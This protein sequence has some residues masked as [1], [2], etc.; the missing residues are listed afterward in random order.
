[1]SALNQYIE[2]YLSNRDLVCDNCGSALN[3]QRPHALHSL[4]HCSLPKIGSENY[5]HTD[6]EEILAPD[7][8]LNLARLNSDINPASAFRCG[9]PNITPALFYVLNDTPV[10]PAEKAELPEGVEIGSLRE[11]SMRGEKW[12]EDHY[13]KLADIGNPVTALDTLLV[14]DGLAIHVKKGVKLEKPLQL[15]NIL[16]ANAPLMA[17]RRLL[18][19]IEDDAKAALLVCDHT[20]NSAQDFLS[21]QTIE[22]FTGKNAEFDL[23]D[24]EESSERTKRLSTLYLSQQQGSN[25]L[26]D[27]ITLYNGRTRNEYHTRFTGRDASLKLLGMGIEDKQRVLE[28]Y[29]RISHDVPGCNTD[30]LFKYVVDDNARGSFTGLV[31]VAPGAEKTTAYQSNRNI[32]GS[33]QALMFSKPQLEIYNDDVKCSHG[34]AIGQ[35]DPLQVFYMR[36][37]GIEEETAKL[38]L[39]QAF[40]ADVIDGVRLPSLRDRLH[41]LVERRFSGNDSS[42]STCQACS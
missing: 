26:I 13:G 40:M 34:S 2:L 18:I 27:G 33:N 8:G 30:E 23:Y 36:T 11:F 16:N 38:L 20:Q 1:M 6:L 35:L 22:I 12:V 15:V 7:Y 14:Q 10:M 3:S 4:Q 31:Y 32:L 29:S 17:V 42:C 19:V 39:K 28:S 25:V 24:L 21:L 41:L 5:E 9:V 37:R